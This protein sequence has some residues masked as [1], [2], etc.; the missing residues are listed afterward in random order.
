MRRHKSLVPLSQDHHNGLMLA[1]LIKKGAPE[2]KG[3][4]TD[5]EGKITYTKESWENELKF[6]FD[7]EENIL[8]PAV[9]GKNDEINILI[10]EL[11]KEHSDIK[12]K[13]NQ[14]NKLPEIENNLNDLGYLLENHIRKEERDFFQKLQKICKS[15]L[16]ELL[17]KIQRANKSCKI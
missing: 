14:L 4:P 2:F 16:D 6:H 17:G 7:N 10:H 8:F 11:I 9:S 15:E 1:Q 12:N 13:I 5:I 3:L